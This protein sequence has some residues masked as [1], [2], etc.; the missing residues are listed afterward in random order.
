MRLMDYDTT[1][2]FTATV[3]STERIT[4]A[5]TDEV[6]EL[7][8]DIDKK[9]FK[10]DPGQSIGVLAPGQKEFGQQHHFRLYTVADLPEKQQGMTRVKLCVKRCNYV[11]EYSGEQFPGIASNYLCN[12]K[13]GDKITMAGPYGLA[14]AVPDEPDANLMLIGAG[15][16]IAPFRAFLKHLHHQQPPFAGKVRLFHGG[17]SGLDLLYQNNKKDDLTLYFDQDTFQAIEALSSRPHWSDDID[18]GGAMKSRGAEIAKLLDD[19]KTYIYVAGL[20][21]IRDQ[22]DKVFSSVLGSQT[23]WARRK[24]ELMAG[25]RWVELLY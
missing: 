4:D 14:F 12:L 17:R 21:K 19:A 6:R 25:K 10:A 16:G 5:S 3:A 18:W 7:Q 2:Q 22:L 11:D 23:R 1:T 8:L 15:T 13:A 20:E 24:A 9:G